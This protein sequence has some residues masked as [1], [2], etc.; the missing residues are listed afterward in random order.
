MTIFIALDLAFEQESAVD[1]GGVKQIADAGIVHPHEGA[2][3][4]RRGR[5]TPK[6]G[7]MSRARTAGAPAESTRRI[8][9]RRALPCEPPPGHLDTFCRYATRSARSA[10]SGMPAYGMRLAGT[11]FCG[12][13]MNASRACA[14]QVMPLRLSAGE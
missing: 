3:L 8:R 9:P 12:S 6:P 13:A 11:A 7:S 2:N 1:V 5:Y 4:L 14:V 10:A